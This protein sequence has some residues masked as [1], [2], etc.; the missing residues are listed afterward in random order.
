MEPDYPI[1]SLGQHPPTDR[2]IDS[3]VEK[4]LAAAATHGRHGSAHHRPV[5][6]QALKLVDGWGTSILQLSCCNGRS[7]QGKNKTRY[8]RRSMHRTAP[9]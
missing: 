8:R 2:G 4:M 5:R 1:I 7:T 3:P 9:D 6:V